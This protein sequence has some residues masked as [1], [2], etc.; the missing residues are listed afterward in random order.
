[1]SRKSTLD[2]KRRVAEAAQAYN[3]GQFSL[4]SAAARE[5]NIF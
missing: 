4:I 5:F 2:Y 1:M 3:S